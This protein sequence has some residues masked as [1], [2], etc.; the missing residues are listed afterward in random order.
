MRSEKLFELL[1]DSGATSLTMVPRDRDGKSLGV[2]VVV[3]ESA[4][5]EFLSV[6]EEHWAPKQ[7]DDYGWSNE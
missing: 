4:M 5:D 1:D 6:L 3:A 2:I 7:K